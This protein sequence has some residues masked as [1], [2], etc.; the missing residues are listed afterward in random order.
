MN[1]IN[2]PQPAVWV[3]QTSGVPRLPYCN[4]HLPSAYRGTPHV[5]PAPEE[6]EAVVE[7]EPEK[8]KPKP[9]ARKKPASE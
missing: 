9:R 2:C 4:Q 1:C 7:P 6:P 8:P 3:F 5:A